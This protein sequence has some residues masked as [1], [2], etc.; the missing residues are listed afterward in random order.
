MTH[1]KLHLA[2]TQ[3]DKRVL[4]LNFSLISNKVFTQTNIGLTGLS[5]KLKVKNPHALQ[6]C[7][8][9]AQALRCFLKESDSHFDK[10]KNPKHYISYVLITE[11]Q[12]KSKNFQKMSDTHKKF[13]L[14]DT[15]IL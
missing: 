14:S 9:S 5:Y 6:A 2:I 1:H 10:T 11:K 15:L 7:A 12:T 13:Y 3:K 8:D 4:L